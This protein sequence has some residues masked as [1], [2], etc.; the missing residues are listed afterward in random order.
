MEIKEIL[1][2]KGISL[3][4]FA[5]DFELARN[6]VLQYITKYEKGEKIPKEKYQIVFKQLFNEENNDEFDLN[7]VSLK[8]LIQRDKLNGMLDLTPEKTDLA[9]STLKNFISFLGDDSEDM[10]LW[11]FINAIVSSANNEIIFKTLAKYF[12]F[13][14]HSTEDDYSNL[15]LQDKA[16]YTNYFKVFTMQKQNLLSVDESVER[17]FISRLKEMSMMKD[18]STK[19]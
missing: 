7:Y 2:N 15:S 1:K 6:T 4:K 16:I 17:L 5:E 10:Y 19:K 8:F 11:Y 3:S 9:M 14:N 18:F 13:F 12:Y